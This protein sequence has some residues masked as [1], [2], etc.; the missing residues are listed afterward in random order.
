MLRKYK[1][2]QV[3]STCVLHNK[4]NSPTWLNVGHPKQTQGPKDYFRGSHKEFLESQV[5]AY[6]ANK[7]GTHQ[8]FWYELYCTW[9]QRYPWKLSDNKEPP[10]DDS[11]KMAQLTLVAP[12]DKAVKK[13]VEKQLTKVHWILFSIVNQ[14]LIKLHFSV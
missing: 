4:G 12:G 6:L 10:T 7:K 14:K 3:S 1:A 8:K 13:Q 11:G 2:K 5:D 9:W